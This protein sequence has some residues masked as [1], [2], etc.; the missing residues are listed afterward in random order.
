[1]NILIAGCGRV[2][3]QL[4]MLMSSEN[5][6]VTIMDADSRAFAKLNTDFS[7][8]VLVG[9]CTSEASM[10]EAGVEEADAFIV[11]TDQDNA[12][13]MSA[14]LAKH[15]F[16]IPKVVCLLRDPE[17]ADFYRTIGL[18]TVSPTLVFAQ[19]LKDKVAG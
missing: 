4:A 8:T 3:A 12:N 19:L 2:G 5:H 14:Q 18:E 15:I 9:D 7:G 13:I 11:V 6:Q 16:N 17:R 1:M 10:R